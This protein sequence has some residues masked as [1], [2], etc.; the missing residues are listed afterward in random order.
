M[1]HGI[2][3]ASE[4][5]IISWK[6]NIYVRGWKLFPCFNELIR[7]HCDLKSFLNVKNAYVSKNRKIYI[8]IVFI[9]KKY[10]LFYVDSISTLSAIDKIN[11]EHP[12][13]VAHI[14]RGKYF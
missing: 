12:S 1:L 4:S 2:K 11:Y 10:M 14:G 3:N 8:R 6:L 7:V 9:I 5:K 13:R